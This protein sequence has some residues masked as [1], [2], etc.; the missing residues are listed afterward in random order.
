[1]KGATLGFW[2]IV[3]AVGVGGVD[4]WL[5]APTHAQGKGSG[6]WVSHNFDRQNSR[7]SP[8]DQINISNVSRLTQQW[9]IRAGA[10]GKSDA[11][12]TGT[13]IR[14]VTPLV[15]DG[16]MYYNAGNRLFA[17]DAATGASLWTHAI[18]PPFS[19]SGRGPSYG[20]G[21][22]YAYGGP[23]GG[24]VL[25]AIDAR[26]G[27]PLQSFG[28][29]GRLLVAEEVVKFKYPR[30]EAGGY[31]LVG[32]PTYLNGML[33]FGL[34]NSERHIPGGLVAA[35]DA[36][37]GAVKWVFSTIP[38]SPAD[39]GWEAA[40]DSW[41]GGQRVGGG[42]WTQPAIDP[43]LGLMYVNA[44]NPSPDYE[45]T[46]RRGMNLFTNSILALG[47]DTG[48][49][50]WYF[51]TI[52]HDLWDWDL[53][54]GPMLFDVNVGGRTVKGVATAGKN[55]FLY[56]FHRETGEPINPIVETAVRTT[57]DVPGEQVWPTQP[58]PYSAK[59]VPMTPFCATFPIVQDPEK[60]KRARPMF[61]PYS[62]SEFFI[63][64][65][66]GSS[67][68]S[69]SFSPRTKLLYVTGKNAALSFTVKVVGDALREGAGDG[70]SATIAKRD[71]DYGVPATETVTA[72]NPVSGE[73]VWQHEHPSNSNIS[74]AGN[75]V[76]GG[77]VIFQGSDTG[78]F[79]AL[80]ARN[81]R[82]LFKV[83][84]SRSIGSSPMT[85]SAKGKQYVAVMG[86]DGMYAFGLP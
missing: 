19:G 51:Q 78:E 44:G 20:D 71:F 82:E 60:A 3:I 33:Y 80:D 53:V 73:V 45:G 62:T 30:K 74:S 12:I 41:S 9:S 14:Q 6:D 43:E 67:W 48:K 28:S 5:A 46:A 79:C 37:T 13:G 11:G 8:L 72:Y 26:S 54:T 27:Q 25:Y 10:D 2:T 52:H 17:V 65:H 75:L 42:I 57:T 86:S 49:L 18:D 1:M 39:D 47:L 69:M 32:P 83:T 59:G 50:A 66:G 7:F 38:Q 24:S 35:M 21:I 84:V 40:K 77:D 55:C 29:K 56:V 4:T 23:Y 81:G 36:K 22:I 70:H 76:T 64:S 31:R 16:V 34:A 68:G 61:W 15:V 85:Y 63:V 58:Y